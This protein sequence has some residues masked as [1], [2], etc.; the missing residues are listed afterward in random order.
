MP[1][2]VNTLDT[3]HSY[4][5]W[6]DDLFKNGFVVV[7]NVIPKE[8]CDYYIAKMFEWAERFPWGFD[9]NDKSTWTPEHL[10][11]HMKGG[12]Y[13]GYRVQH[14]KF[15]WEARTE[16][17]VLET[18]SK[19]WGTDELLV[20]FDGMN[21]TLP[22]G[23]PLP[24]TE[25]WPHVD[26]SPLR[27]GMQC[28]QGILNFAPNGPKDG[29]LLVM[30][31]SSK[32]MPEFFEAHPEVIG[33]Q[34]WGSSDWFGFDEEEVK[35]F[36]DRGCELLKVCADPGDVILW[37]SRTMHHNCVPTSQNLRAIVYACYTPAAFAQPDILRQKA[38]FFDQRM[39]TTHWPH[40]NLFVH[41]KEP[42]RLGKE[43][44][45]KRDRPWEEPVET[46]QIQKLAG[47]L[48]Y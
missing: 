10:P 36:T 25:P 6:R 33:R 11:T 32:L 20:S 18:F 28:V 43:D 14:E 29:G 27:K 16:P 4:G 1:H 22:T 31:G 30:K 48:A 12:M 17:G 24:P 23:K 41:G 15:I 44:N 47:K 42:L 13:H 37:D 39:G 34:T 40:D 8:R 21:F 45:G 38:E 3:T 7:K 35:W 9:R 5:D 19:L 46:E 2:A 26:Q